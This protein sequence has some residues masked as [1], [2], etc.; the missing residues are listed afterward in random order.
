MIKIALNGARP[1]TESRFIPNTPSEIKEDVQKL[2]HAGFTTFHVHIYDTSGKESLA[3]KDLA[4]VIS[5][6]RDISKQIKIG[7]STGD[8]IESDLNKR[9]DHIRSWKIIPDF[10]SVNIVEE[11][12]IEIAEE[13]IRKGIK[14][15]AGLTDP[16][17]AEKF[18]KYGIVKDC[19]RILIE[20]QEQN[21]NEALITVEKIETILDSNNIRVKRLLHGFDDTAWGLINE[22]FKRDYATRIGLEDTIFLPSGKKATGNLELARE[23]LKLKQ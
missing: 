21:L 5:R 10:A 23:A 8:W 13:L 18:V 20:P 4:A 3:Y 15:E 12:S 14:I 17:S 16:E 22:A 6:L 2:F 11:N 9:I 19:I 1:K 7:I